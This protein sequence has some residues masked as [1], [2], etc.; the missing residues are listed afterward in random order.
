ML[1]FKVFPFYLQNKIYKKEGLKNTFINKATC[2]ERARSSLSAIP[3]WSSS[4][5]TLRAG[6]C[7]CC[8]C[9]CLMK[10]SSSGASLQM[11]MTSCRLGSFY[12]NKECLAQMLI[13]L[14]TPAL[15]AY[16]TA[17]VCRTV[18]S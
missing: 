2:K 12:S 17:F 18:F 9:S 3:A 15:S 1:F 6:C 11:S 14:K 7:G 10:R 16:T 8:C 4:S 13:I 5:H